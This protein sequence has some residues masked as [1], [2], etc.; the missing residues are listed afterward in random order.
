M[1][2]DLAQLAAHAADQHGGSA[3]NGSE[4]CLDHPPTQKKTGGRRSSRRRRRERRSGM[5]AGEGAEDGSGSGSSGQDGS[6]RRPRSCSRQGGRERAVREERREEGGG[7]RGRRGARQRGRRPSAT[8]TRDAGTAG[9]DD[10]GALDRELLSRSGA[11]GA[12]AARSGPDWLDGSRMG[13][14]GPRRLEAGR[15]RA[16]G[17]W[18]LL[19]GC[20]RLLGWRLAYRAVPSGKVEVEGAGKRGGGGW[21]WLV[22]RFSRGMRR[23]RG[24]GRLGG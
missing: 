11:W 2:P 5:D 20:R 7:T 8:T 15:G 12:G 16:G 9:H 4:R 6:W 3:V 18:R 17:A 21:I 22:T 13:L 14:P 24:R 10:G 23:D 19:G 1:A